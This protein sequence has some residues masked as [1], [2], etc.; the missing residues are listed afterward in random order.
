MIAFFLTIPASR[1][2]LIKAMSEKSYF[3]CYE[4]KKRSHPSRRQ[5]R[6]DRDGMNETLVQDA[7]D[8][9]DRNNG[10]YDQVRLSDK[11]RLEYSG[12]P[13]KT[14][15]Q[16]CGLLKLALRVLNRGDSM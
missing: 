14:A 2:V 1:M 7:E 13:L 11:R 9:V 5:S 12:R 3:E 6:E 15:G 16:C 8:D 4:G 10:R